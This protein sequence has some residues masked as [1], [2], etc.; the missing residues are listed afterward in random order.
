LGGLLIAEAMSDEVFDEMTSIQ[1][2]VG[3]LQRFISE[4]GQ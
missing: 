1:R 4:D 2:S 3:L